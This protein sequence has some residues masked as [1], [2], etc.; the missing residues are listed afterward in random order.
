MVPLSELD[1][2]EAR[3][4]RSISKKDAD[5][6][7]AGSGSL[8]RDDNKGLPDGTALFS[9]LDHDSIVW[10]RDGVPEELVRN[11]I[12]HLVRYNEVHQNHERLNNHITE[13]IALSMVG[14]IILDIMH[15]LNSPLQ[16]MLGFTQ[17]ILDRLPD[18]SE[19]KEDL[20]WVE[21]AIK[22]LVIRS[23]VQIFWRNPKQAR[24]IKI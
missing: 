12:Q 10:L 4:W 13:F 21:G 7:I 15:D 11:K 14:K 24:G 5:V 18:D 19:F 22:I 23:N 2:F 1:F 3:E 9:T 8:L 16:V 17:N 20:S 6:V